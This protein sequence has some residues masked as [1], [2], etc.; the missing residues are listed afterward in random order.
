MRGGLSGSRPRVTSEPP[1]D[2]VGGTV[3]A[4]SR[5]ARSPNLR[6]PAVRKAILNRM[7]F[8]RQAALERIAE[9]S[10]A[11]TLALRRF[12]QEIAHSGLPELLLQ[13]GAGMPFTRELPQ[14]ALLYLLVRAMRPAHVVETGV[15]PGYSTA[16]I[17]AALEANGSGQLVSLGPGPIQGRAS[18]VANASVG[19]LVA[20]SLRSRWTLVLGNSVERLDEILGMGR[21]VDLFFYDNGPDAARARLELRK[22]WA[23]LAPEG[24]L[25][26]HHVD[27]SPVWAEFC[28]WQGTEP[29]LLDPGPPPLGALSMRL[30]R[31][32]RGGL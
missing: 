8:C 25:L 31:A 23:S 27:A 18:G 1:V 2:V 3:P 13:R 4:S 7:L 29:R 17:L 22:G 5:P 9:L 14:G 15:R 32:R 12:R 30:T 10:G 26:A 6:T 21:P 28:R 16:W 24:I 19:Q 11:D 20:P